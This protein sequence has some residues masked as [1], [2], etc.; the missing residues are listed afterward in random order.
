MR[1]TLKEN[2]RPAPRGSALRARELDQ[3]VF[4]TMSASAGT[5]E[6]LG[7]GERSELSQLAYR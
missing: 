1:P 2:I 4:A 3:H 7:R 6:Q 5:G